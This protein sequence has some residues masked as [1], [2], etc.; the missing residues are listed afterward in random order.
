MLA[1]FYRCLYSYKL[2]EDGKDKLQWV[3]SRK[4]GFEVKSFYQALSAHRPI[5]F[6]WKSI[7]RSKAPPRVAFF[8]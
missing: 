1:S 4:V 2:R 8:A 3:P 6:P 5:S 7:W